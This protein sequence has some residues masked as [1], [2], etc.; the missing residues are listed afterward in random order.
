[1]KAGPLVRLMAPIMALSMLPLAGGVG[2]AF[3][4]HHS[5]KQASD[6]LARNVASMRAAEE[7]V[8]AIRDVRAKLF[9]FLL[10]EDRAHLEDVPALLAAIE[11]WLAVT[12][13]TAAAGRGR[14]I[15]DRVKQGYE[16][17]SPKLARLVRH[18][19]GPEPPR[20]TRELVE[21]ALRDEMLEPAQEYLDFI[22]EEIAG[23]SADNQR[24]ADRMVLGLLLLG[25]CGPLAG[26]LAGL[27][28]SRAVSRSIVRLSVP[29]R[30]AAGKLDGIV[31][32]VTLAARWGLDELEGVLRTIAERIGAVVARLQQSE[33]EARRAE[34]LAAVGQM[35]AGLAHE[36]RNPL[37]PIKILVQAA[38]ERD[39][40]PGLDRRDLAVLEEE[41]GRLE[42]SI[43]T[44]LDFARP[45]QLEK[46]TFDAVAVLR[47]V[48]DLLSA[49]AARQEVRIE[50]R[51]PPGPLP[52]WADV[53]QVRQVMLNL[54]LN[55]LD[56]VPPGGTV[57]LEL[58]A[59]GGWLTLRVK[60]TGR[61]LPAE[62]G[63]R[64]FE[65]FV[66]TRETGLGLGLSICKRIV[67]AH[68]GEILAAD[69]PGGGAVFTVRLPLPAG[70]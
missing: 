70:A 41:I 15:I 8:L 16:S 48:A 44:F 60:D 47:Q 32:P 33:R 13:Q 51:T 22:E 27:G 46:R 37:M 10:T 56:A 21:E 26:L 66:S 14:Q 52:V 38:A 6:A 65:P 2:A 5:Q 28:I 67:E 61:G 9:D 34:H 57:W 53:G 63:Q 17:F 19:A 40:S 59:E 11:R 7:L 62:L 50:C 20:R 68:E 23:T 69:R 30:D 24:V 36:M 3:Y 54:L 45:P 35:A 4:V 12:E 58:A 55:A 25:V 49:R 39:P 42:R 29:I 64:I 1:M 31:G 18:P 43:Q